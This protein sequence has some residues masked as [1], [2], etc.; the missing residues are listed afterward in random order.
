[1]RIRLLL[2]VFFWSVSPF[3]RAQLADAPMQFAPAVDVDGAVYRCKQAANGFPS[4][5]EKIFQNT[6]NIIYTNT[7]Y[8]HGVVVKGDHLF[9]ST[10]RNIIGTTQQEIGVSCI[11]K[12][13]GRKLWDYSKA[14]EYMD[15]SP[16]AVISVQGNVL[17]GD[18]VLS[19][20]GTKIRSMKDTRGVVV[21][22]NGIAVANTD[23]LRAFSI[24][25]GGLIWELPQGGD[26]QSQATRYER[27]RALPALG[28]S[29]N[30]YSGL[31]D[32]RVVC[33]DLNTGVLNWTYRTGGRI[34]FPLVLDG[35]ENVY[36]MASDGGLY[37]IEGATGELLWRVEGP[38]LWR[39][40]AL[41][42]KDEIVAVQSDPYELAGLDKKTGVLKWRS[43][44]NL[45]EPL[46]EVA[47]P[48]L[49]PN[50]DIYFHGSIIKGPFEIDSESYW[51]RVLGNPTN[52]QSKEELGPP[53]F[54]TEPSISVWTKNGATFR[55]VAK[56]SPP[57]EYVWYLNDEI[58]PSATNS[59]FVASVSSAQ[60]KVKVRVT[61]ALGEI[62]SEPAGVGYKVEAVEVG[63][64]IRKSPDL[65]IVPEGTEVE[66]VAEA[67]GSNRFVAW[68]KPVSSTNSAIRIT[69]T[70]N[71]RAIARFWIP[72]GEKI[73]ERGLGNGVRHLIVGTEALYVVAEKVL[74][75]FDP[76]SYREK[77]AIPVEFPIDVVT[78]EKG[79]LFY[80]TKGALKA[81]KESDLS[82]IWEK[83]VPREAFLISD[84]RGTIWF[85]S[86]EGIIGL[87][88]K[89]G[90]ERQRIPEAAY[91]GFLGADG[92]LYYVSNWYA[93]SY[94][95]ISRQTLWSKNR[96]ERTILPGPFST[97]IM[98]SYYSGL[99]FHDS[100]T[101]DQLQ[102]HRLKLSYFPPLIVDER[103]MVHFQDDNSNSGRLDFRRSTEVGWPS[104]RREPHLVA[105]KDKILWNTSSGLNLID[106]ITEEKLWEGPTIYSPTFFD[107]NTNLVTSD[108]QYLKFYSWG[109]KPPDAILSTSLKTH[110]TRSFLK[111]G[112]PRFVVPPRNQFLKPNL[113][114]R[115]A[116]DATGT[117]PLHYQWFKN[118]APILTATNAALVIP[119]TPPPDPSARY[120]VKVSN[121]LGEIW[122]EEIGGGYLVTPLGE[123]GNVEPGVFPE[124]VLNTE[125]VKVRALMGSSPRPF[126][127]WQSPY[128]STNAQ[129]EITIASN[130]I[131]RGVYSTRPGDF[132]RR[133]NL[134]R[135]VLPTENLQQPVIRKY[136][137]NEVVFLRD[138]R[139]VDLKGGDQHL[140]F[141]DVGEGA[142]HAL[143]REF[144]LAGTNYAYYDVSGV[145][146]RLGVLNL[147]TGQTN[148]FPYQPDGQRRAA[149]DSSENIIWTY[150]NNL[151][152]WDV[153][154]RK[155]WKYP[156]RVQEICTLS[157]DFVA[158]IESGTQ[159]LHLIDGAT[160]TPVK[161]ID[162][163]FFSVTPAGGSRL[164][165]GAP[166]S[167][168]DPVSEEIF[169][170]APFSENE[171]LINQNGNF[172]SFELDVYSP[173][174]GFIRRLS[175]NT[176]R[177]L[178]L[179]NNNSAL[180]TFS[181]EL[182]N[183]DL[184][185]GET[186]W[187]S[188][189]SLD[190][191]SFTGSAYIG[192]DAKIYV[193]SGSSAIVVFQ[194][195]AG[196]DEGPW[197]TKDG[198]H[199]VRR[200]AEPG[201]HPLIVRIAAPIGGNAILEF[202]GPPGRIIRIQRT[203]KLDNV[204]W[205]DIGERQL[206]DGSAE[207][208]LTVEPTS[209]FRAVLRP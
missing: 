177:G 197:P 146:R 184:A 25:T 127:G 117:P 26:T 53:S 130:T 198:K 87:D 39:G 83:P 113:P 172:L 183:F 100:K 88:E 59:F 73:L 136:L 144:V 156:V 93:K 169:W 98:D 158:A 38:P 191:P 21:A 16:P 170:S 154:G 89:T 74:I 143:Y 149:L 131:A 101:G 75:A 175:Y 40:T 185:S 94:N 161:K 3:S 116:V 70:N 84:P 78:N 106:S 82:I 90:L 125:T 195:G 24:E 48:T 29:G 114:L 45:K 22:A 71:V 46:P 56:G 199:G 72:P 67:S 157:N 6:T 201:D 189:G 126:L 129:L 12:Q 35:Q 202:S 123:G 99:G 206:V 159:F 41:V 132:I 105:G 171:V 120:S 139:I 44:L 34:Y 192:S 187:V 63:G 62:M 31:T 118:Q 52:N 96:V 9:L 205:V 152:K 18:A 168:I 135:S 121:S 181:S 194:G 4:F 115:L 11:E 61:N 49:L 138:G 124:P 109:E 147:M 23:T 17:W 65:S 76:E 148:L 174:G 180:A 133:I 164:I 33:V 58:V 209:F 15:Y 36:V 27:T 8:F 91:Q 80:A 134:P 167:L 55:T 190:Q 47:S 51:P 19:P 203:P 182:V 155:H 111:T 162:K 7:A 204:Q 68:E 60:D 163:K 2:F 122:S 97:T 13:S 50:G 160:G 193:F 95:P 102:Y 128:W 140:V 104:H 57:L 43:R 145:D 42:L 110:P 32:G 107:G 37:A 86:S 30:V 28:R 150:A 208:V 142:P 103:G 188:T 137:G 20:G 176:V 166:L 179:M 196:P 151:E 79:L 10:A 14:V 165:N 69:V 173:Q 1:M 112:L 64:K 85:F 77:W 186:K 119:A 153:G 5:I 81:L 200:V 92:N 66:L 207:F 108:Y 178:S 54:V 141:A